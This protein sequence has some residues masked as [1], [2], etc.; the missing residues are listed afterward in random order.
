MAEC[1]FVSD[2]CT[3]V[4]PANG[5]AIQISKNQLPN[6]TYPVGT[7]ALFHCYSGYVR[8]AYDAKCVQPGIWIPRTPGCSPE[9]QCE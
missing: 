4:R 6:G 1:K 7:T 5:L 3:D 2:T 8:N 9:N